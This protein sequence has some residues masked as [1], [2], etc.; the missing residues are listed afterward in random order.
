MK[1]RQSSGFESK[2]K[3]TQPKPTQLNPSGASRPR[4]GASRPRGLAQVALSQPKAWGSCCLGA[5][6]S[7][8]GDFGRRSMERCQTKVPDPPSQWLPE[9]PPPPNN[10][11]V[12]S[13]TNPTHTNQP[14]S[15]FPQHPP[16]TPTSGFPL[17][18][19]QKPP[20]EFFQGAFAGRQEAEGWLRPVFAAGL[21]LCLKA[22]RTPQTSQINKFNLGVL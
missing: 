10:Q 6:G 12:V 1:I 18:A 20:K 8:P 17:V 14:T 4:S 19:L 16:P 5:A 22:V 11:P 9:P 3:P 15:G 13:P 2:P 21:R 7:P